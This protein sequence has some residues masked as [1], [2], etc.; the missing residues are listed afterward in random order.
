MVDQ[1]TPFQPGINDVVDIGRCPG[2]V[3]NMN[4]R[5]DD[6]SGTLENF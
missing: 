2:V 6:R 1:K 5:K 3:Q 4:N